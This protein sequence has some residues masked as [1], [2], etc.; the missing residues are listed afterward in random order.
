M[1]GPICEDNDLFLQ[2]VQL[3][4]N[5]N[6]E[7]RSCAKVHNLREAKPSNITTGK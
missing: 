2:V 3:A 1:I 5:M 7:M 6:E 4:G